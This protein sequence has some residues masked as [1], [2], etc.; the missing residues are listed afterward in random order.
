VYSEPK[1]FSNK[2]ISF[3]KG[4]CFRSLEFVLRG[5]FQVLGDSL[6]K[7]DIGGCCPLSVETRHQPQSTLQVPG[8]KG[9][10]S[11]SLVQQSHEVNLPK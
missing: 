1:V 8:N 7:T 4:S 3:G 9:I 6:W 5:S 11:S 2:P 10:A